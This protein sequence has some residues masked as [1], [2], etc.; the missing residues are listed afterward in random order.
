M[1]QISVKSV[2]NQLQIPRVEKGIIV[3]C[4]KCDSINCIKQGKRKT[5]LRGEIQRY[6]CKKCNHRFSV[7]A[8]RQRLPEDVIAFGLSLFDKGKSSYQII[9]LIKKKFKIQV[10]SQTL[11]RWAK[12]FEG[13][14]PINYDKRFLNQL[15]RIQDKSENH[16]KNTRTI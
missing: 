5:I 2:S 8:N 3:L 6:G 4:P 16:K 14:K 11:F 1:T 12:K 9:R 15:K 13:Y 10:S 7:N